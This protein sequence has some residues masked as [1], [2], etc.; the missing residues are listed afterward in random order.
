MSSIDALLDAAPGGRALVIDSDAYA[1]AVLRQGGEIPWGDLA[2]LTG[3]L[4]QVHA[5]LN[6]DAV[7]IDAQAFYGARLAAGPDLVTAMGARDRAGYAL[8]TLLGDEPATQA[9]AAAVRTLANSTRRLVVLSVP[10]PGRWLTRAHDL[11]GTPLAEISNDNADR[12]A[13]Y[14]AEWLG[15]LGSVALALLVLDAR[16]GTAESAAIESREEL[17]NYPSL[18][19]VAGHF[20]LTLALR[21]DSSVEVAGGATRAVVLPEAFWHGQGEAPTDGAQ[22]VL[23]TIPADALPETVLARR[24]LLKEG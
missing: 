10:S 23:T 5:L 22:L 2:A 1:T 18:T 15:R 6:P 4:T 8:R 21:S 14:L 7:F 16:T 17:A 24:A 13:T 3:H 19:N 11:A 12:A 20:G 9:L